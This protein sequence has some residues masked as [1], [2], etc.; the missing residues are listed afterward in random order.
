M[1]SPEPSHSPRPLA[2]PDPPTSDSMTDVWRKLADLEATRTPHVLVQVLSSKGSVPQDPGSKMVVEDSG[3]PTGT[4]GGGKMEAAAIRLAREML[5]GEESDAPVLR[6]VE[7]N[8]QSDLGMSCG[9][10]VRLLFEARYSMAWRVTIFGAGHVAQALV[11]VLIPLPVS[12]ECV[13]PR[14]DWLEKL[15]TAPNLRLI[16]LKQPEDHVQS[17]PPATFILAIT[18][19][20][21]TDLPILN[22][23]MAAGSFGFLGCI[24]SK[25]K[26]AKL[27]A[28][29]LAAGHPPELVDTLHC[30]L[31]LEIGTNHPHEIAL[32]I[33]AQL[34]TERD[35]RSSDA[36]GVV[37]RRRQT[38]DRAIDRLAGRR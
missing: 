33:A 14:A 23:A 17:L 6:E 26:A 25:V 11:P 37:G 2:S 21:T 19:G 32:S 9:G 16:H 13:D 1:N 5:A 8:L 18:Q 28:E 10:A 15:P 12:L 22:A 34:L 20:H 38:P 24:G 7:W 4:V 31:G 30:P 36:H 29:L 27:R 35:L 3:H